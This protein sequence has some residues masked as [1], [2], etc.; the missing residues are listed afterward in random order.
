MTDVI[1]TILKQA[2]RHSS[3][4]EVFHQNGEVQSV[5][6]ENNNLKK[7]STRQYEGI[8]LR[9]IIDGRIGFA[10]ST[11]LRS[12][13]DLVDM[14]RESAQFGDQAQF[15]F[16]E[17][18]SSLHEVNTADHSISDWRADDIKEMGAQALEE[19]RNS[20]ENYLFSATITTSSCD[21]R[22]V[23]S[24]GLDITRPSTRMSASTEIQETREDGLLQA[25]ESKSWN[26]PFSS[27]L[28]IT[29]DALQ[30]MKQGS[31]VV[32]PSTA[33]M[34]VIFVP[35]SVHNLLR[36]IMTAVNGKL[37][38]K[39]SSVLA[40]R[41][42][43]H[44]LDP[45]LSIYD[46]A[47]IDFAPGSTSMDDEG[48]PTDKFP[49]FEEGVLRNYLIDQQTSGHLNMEPTGSGYRSYSKRPSPSSSNTIILPGSMDLED[50]IRGM[51]RALIVDQTLGSG[52]S[53]TLA[54]EFSVN[55]SLGLLVEDGTI[56]GRV[57]DAMVAGNVYDLLKQI[58]GLGREQKWCGSN[59]LPF[60]CIKEMKLST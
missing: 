22:L 18:P 40:D 36:P 14:A 4:C 6:F 54:G 58:E 34:P 26:Q 30:K 60:I 50:C 12:P 59:Y 57:K 5:V 55:V 27:I 3:S 2:E 52:Q 35:K 53:N 21:E 15:D 8:G 9:L 16:P 46:D 31:R 49:L 32:S 10:S 48:W 17:P 29:R 20:N 23:N 44:I 42:G 19:S 24:R 11:D 7:I 28:D 13:A 43:E 38:H 25:Y 45:R 39:G 33:T 1:D 41:V 51:D 56:R 37:V 47:T